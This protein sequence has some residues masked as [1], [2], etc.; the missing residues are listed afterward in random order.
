MF[1]KQ[2]RKANHKKDYFCLMI[3][4]T[5]GTGLVGSHLLFK[6]VTTDTLPIRATYRDIQKLDAVKKIF[7]YY[8]NDVDNLYNRIEWIKADIN[9]ITALQDAFKTVSYVYH[10][11]ALVS[12]DPNRY[13]E[14]RTVNIKGTANIVNLSISNQITKLCYVSSIAAIGKETNDND[15]ITETTEWNPEQD[16]GVYAI[17]KY[18]AEMEIWRG[19]QEGV[20]AVI[21]NPGIILGPGFWDSSGS[22]GIFKKIHKGLKFYPKGTS[23]YIDVRDVSDCMIALMN[24]TITNE[25]YILVTENMSYKDFQTKVA[26]TLDTAPAKKEASALLLSL[27]WRIDW[28]CHRLYGK[29]RILSKQMAK[30]I[31]SQSLFDNSKLKRDLHFKLTPIEQ[32][33]TA[34]S[35]YYLNDLKSS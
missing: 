14:L 6:L 7:S 29:S 9:D 2:K 16:N 15:L 26:Q 21:I 10:C 22:G 35:N 12:F 34:I 33:I 17:T 28:L 30:S 32:S 24:S 8:S 5:G 20:D 4:V 23:G 25:R 11:A 13:H 3:L 19:T 27:A 31:S 18:G 1:I